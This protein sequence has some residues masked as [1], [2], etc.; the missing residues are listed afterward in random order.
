MGI[1]MGATY[2]YQQYEENKMAEKMKD[3]IQR[4]ATS[5]LYADQAKLTAQAY[6]SLPV[7][8]TLTELRKRLIPE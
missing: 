6:C 2:A 8:A 1:I 5:R 4:L 7:L 3:G